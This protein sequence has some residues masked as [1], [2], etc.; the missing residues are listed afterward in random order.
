MSLPV[1]L[2]QSDTRQWV[3]QICQEKI[4]ETGSYVEW[5]GRTWAVLES[6]HHYF[7]KS[8]TYYLHRVSLFV[9]PV[10]VELAD[11]VQVGD[12]WLIGDATCRFNAQSE[13]LRCVPNPVGPCSGCRFREPRE[14]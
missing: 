14:A 13:L 12:R 10:A 6:S 4:L 3:G 9:R 1:H 7:L 11:R 8:G 5:E 2:Y